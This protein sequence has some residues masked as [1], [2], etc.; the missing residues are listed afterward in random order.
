MGRRTVKVTCEMCGDR[1]QE[2]VA[3]PVKTAPSIDEKLPDEVCNEC[4]RFL[5]I[6]VKPLKEHK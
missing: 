4:A 3:T 2:L 6:I 5:R 1:V